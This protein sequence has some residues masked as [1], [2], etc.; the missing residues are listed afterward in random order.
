MKRRW[1]HLAFGAG[2]LVCAAL[3]G[4][5]TARLYEAKRVNAA[6]A[7]ARTGARLA[8]ESALPEALLAQANDLARRGEYEAALQRYKA[9]S[10]GARADLAT[11]ALY[12]AGNLHY[13]EAFRQGKDAGVRMLPLLELA[14]QS[15]RSALRR[16]PQR[17]DARYNLDR[18]LWLAPE[19]DETPT[20]SVPR[21][22]ESRVM[23]TLQSTRADLP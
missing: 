8:Q 9:L 22:A 6:I 18:A 7:S 5:Q 3:A 12:N 4:Y 11:D 13:R 20:L 10:R 23:S 19:L 21:N 2:V 14:K 1:V 17:W 15:Y 16:D